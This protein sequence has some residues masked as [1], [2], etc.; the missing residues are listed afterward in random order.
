MLDPTR[1][2]AVTFDCYGTLIDWEAGIR[3]YVA[4]ILQRKMPS[5]HEQPDLRPRV[6]PDEWL[7]RWEPIQ[8][9]LLRPYKRYREILALSF[10]ETMRA[11]GLE[12]FVD[13]G[14]GLWRAVPTW[15]PFPDTSQALRRLGRRFS[16][17]IVS[18][19]DDDLLA[20]TL[21]QLGAPVSLLVTAE[22]ARAYKPDP[23]PLRL[24][25]E[26]LGLAPDEVLH[27]GFGWRYDLAPARSLGMRTCFVNR[28]G[29]PR[30]GGPEPDVEVPSVAALADLLGA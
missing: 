10:A 7:A 15:T 29:K 1:I 26:R 4:P 5:R 24:A 21:A 27:A 12:A 25:L 30:P 6:T 18:N 2:R 23:A 19:I 17:G 11:F 20:G 13:E 16:V 28:D 14:H 8:F 22:Q 3:A 9:D